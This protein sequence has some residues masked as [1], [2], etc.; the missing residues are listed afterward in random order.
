[1]SGKDAAQVAAIMVDKRNLLRGKPTSRVERMS[2]SDKLKQLADQFRAYVKGRVLEGEFT[3]VLGDEEND[4]QEGQE[5]YSE[6]RGGPEFIET[7]VE[8]SR[9]EAAQAG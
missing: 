5:I 7:S 1:M 6:E 9:K 3:K 8:E 2:E 4:R